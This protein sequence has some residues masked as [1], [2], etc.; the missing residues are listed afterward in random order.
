MTQGP[1]YRV[2]FRRRREGRT[3]YY[4]R[5]RLLL[6]RQPRLVIRKT[7]TRTIVQVIEATVNGDRTLASA[8]S[9]ELPWH[10]WNAGTANLP[11]AYLTGLLAGRRAKSKGITNAVLDIGLN[12]PIKGCKIYAAL[13]GVLDAGIEVPHSE[14]VLPD[15]ERITG[16]HI[17]DA[18]EHVTTVNENTHMFSKFDKK[19]LME[20]PKTFE[21]IKKKI[22]ALPEAELLVSHKPEAPKKAV[23]EKPAVRPKHKEPVP[24]APR[25]KPRKPRPKKLVSKAKGKKPTKVGVT[26]AEPTVLGTVERKADASKSGKATGTTKEGAE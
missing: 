10:G 4:R 15:K 3:D 2:K 5:R 11:A 8:I 17:A 6:S 23:V 20:L 7:N 1:T 9:S 25:A 19:T 16:K 26:A 24:K 18:Y 13:K 22:M 21:S 12:P 14:D